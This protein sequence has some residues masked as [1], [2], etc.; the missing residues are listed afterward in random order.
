MG[1][2]GGGG[3]NNWQWGSMARMYGGYSINKVCFTLES[4]NVTWEKGRKILE[5]SNLHTDGSVVGC[6]SFQMKCKQHGMM[7]GGNKKGTKNT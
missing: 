4:L 5:R 3:F 2:G 7:E 6:R 1:G